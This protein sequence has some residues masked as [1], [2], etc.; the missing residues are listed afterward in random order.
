MFGISKDNFNVNVSATSNSNNNN[1]LV[2][3][4]S[5]LSHA[6]CH[7]LAATITTIR[8]GCR[9]LTN[10]VRYLWTCGF[11]L[12]VFQ[13]ASAAF[14]WGP[15]DIIGAAF[16]V[17]VDN[18]NNDDDSDDDDPQQTKTSLHM[19]LVT[20]VIGSGCLLGPLIVNYSGL[21][22]A[23][24][25]WTLQRACILGLALQTLGWL[26]IGVTAQT[27]EIFLACTLIRTMGS[28]IV[29]T[30]ATLM[31][32]TLVDKEYLGRVLAIQ[33]AGSTLVEAFIATLIGSLQDAGW[34]KH[35][36]ALWS[37]GIGSFLVGVWAIYY[38]HYC[39][40]ACCCCCPGDGGVAPIAIA[41]GYHPVEQQL[42]RNK[43]TE[44]SALDDDDDD[45]ESEKF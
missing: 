43:E 28:G 20:S 42:V 18:N 10:V 27:F 7:C 44:L 26:A 4:S 16:S 30:N 3:D 29:W 36:L 31:L 9:S 35:W 5:S 6:C 25:P 2:D 15:E 39:C 32:Q 21:A 24:R 13:R 19:G 41:I 40:S 11:G 45:D 23:A 33:Y 12:L 8:N 22:D 38:Y 34:D 14:L 1:T 17:T 37:A